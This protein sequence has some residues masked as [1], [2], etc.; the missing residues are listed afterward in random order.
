[1]L[2][3]VREDL[4]LR[5]I[6]KYRQRRTG[7]L[8]DELDAV[9]NE[10]ANESPDVPDDAVHVEHFRPEHLLAAE[11]QQLPRQQ[12]RPMSGPLDFTKVFRP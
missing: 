10:P 5:S 8:D 1:V 3:R 12:A 2:I 6:A 9:A 4:E 11:C 7:Q